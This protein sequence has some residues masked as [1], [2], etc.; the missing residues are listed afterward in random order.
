MERVLWP[1]WV[2]FAAHENVR[3]LKPAADVVE[4]VSER[5]REQLNSNPLRSSPS[6]ASCSSSPASSCISS[7]GGGKRRTESRLGEAARRAATTRPKRAVE[8]ARRRWRLVALRRRPGRDH[9][10]RC[11]RPVL[12]AWKANKTLVLLFV[13]DGGIDD[14]LVKTA[15]DGLGRLPRRRDLRRPGRPD[16]PLR[17]DHP[18]RR[19]RPRAGAGR[20]HAQAPRPDGVPTA[21]VSYGFQSPRERR[22]GRDRRRLQGPDADYHP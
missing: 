1:V 15:T 10:R 2:T 12:D 4:L 16:R 17:G 7:S 11:P 18:G 6:S 13:R 5:M 3:G 20:G 22:P 19:R 9:R 21:S 14:R 8:A